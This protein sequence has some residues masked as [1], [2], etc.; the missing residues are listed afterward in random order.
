MQ[1]EQILYM[2]G[3]GL[4]DTVFTL[5]PR[6][7]GEHVSWNVTRLM[8]DALRGTFGAPIKRDFATWPAMSSGE[9]AN[10]DWDKVAHFARHPEIM[11]KPAI[12]VDLDAGNELHRHIVDGNHRVTARETI[13]LLYFLMWIV[14]PDVE[15]QYRVTF[16]NG[17]GKPVHLPL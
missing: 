13:G 7:S 11:A 2:T 1:P 4:S 15:T 10:I 9:R 6:L 12:A 5:D 8:T 16:K 14:P 3:A 17:N